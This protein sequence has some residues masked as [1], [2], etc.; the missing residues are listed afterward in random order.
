[1]P[2]PS[3]AT[4]NIAPG[5]AFAG[6]FHAGCVT[7]DG[8]KYA[9]VVAPKREGETENVVWKVDWHSV[10][11]GT[12]SL[13]DGY[14]NSQAMNDENHPAAKWARSL[15]IAGFDDWYL[16][17][18]DELEILYRAFKPGTD[19]NFTCADRAE[20]WGVKPGEYNGIDEQGNGHNPASDPVG[21]AYTASDPARTDLG[22]FRKGGPE[23]FDEAWY[24][25]SSEFSSDFS[26]LQYFG[27][28][29]QYDDI[30][31]GAL[32][33]RAIRKVPI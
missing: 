15:R 16:P 29:Q 26:W 30:K 17:S 33:A 21:S 23:A 28:G 13:C 18:R 24:W 7:I 2:G 11:P 4:P 27:N 9:V 14:A 31:G 22:L 20:S 25:S 19:A 5:T 6:G 8:K 10:T 1:M 12:R 3:V 32:S